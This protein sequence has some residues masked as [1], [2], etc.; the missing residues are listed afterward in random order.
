[1]SEIRNI[2]TLYKALQPYI[3]K[4]IAKASLGTTVVR[5]V[6]SG[7]GD[8]G[9]GDGDGGVTDHSELTNVTANQHHNQIHAI[10]GADHTG[11]LAHSS[12]S[13][14]T[15]SDH[16]AP[17]TAGDGIDLSGQQVSV[18]VTDIIDTSTGLAES[19][20]NI[21]I[22]YA[23]TG[24]L[25]V[26]SSQLKIG[27]PGSVAANSTNSTG[28]ATHTHAVVA[29]S[30]PGAS[31]T[32]LKSTSAGGLT[33]ESFL[34]NGS[35][36]ALGD[37]YA[38]QSGF[39]VIN[40]THDGDHAHVIINPTVGWS[41]D[42]QFGLDVDDNLLV[43]GWIVGKHAIQV[44]GAKLIAHFDGPEPYETNFDGEGMGHMGQVPT[45]LGGVTFHKGKFL[46]AVQMA[47]ATTNLVTNPSFETNTTGWSIFNDTGGNLA[48]SR[49]ADDSKFGVYSA[50]LTSTT[51]NNSQFY[52]AVSGGFVSGTSYSGS[53]WMRAASSE[54]VVVRLRRNG[55][56][57]E[58]YVSQTFA[59][60]TEWQR[61][62]LSFT[63]AATV[64]GRISIEPQ[65]SGTVYVDGVQVE[66]LAYATPYCDG[67]LGGYSASGVYDGSGHSWSGTAHA[68]T[69][70]RLASNLHY[71]GISGNINNTVG[72]VMLWAKVA[73]LG[74][75]GV[76][77][78]FFAADS[79][80]NRYIAMRFDSS[81][82][83]FYFWD[84]SGTSKS[85]YAPDGEWHHYAMSSDGSTVTLYVD[86]IS[87]DSYS[88]SSPITENLTEIYVGCRETGSQLNG[89]IDDFAIFDRAVPA[90][91]IRAIYESNAP[92][93]GET[94]TWHWRAGR[95]RVWA[96][97][98]GLWMLNASGTAVLGAY[99]G[100]ED[101]PSTTKSWGGQ[102]LS[103]SD[104]LIGD[105]NRGGYVKWDD[106]A[107]TLNVK[108]TILMQS[109]S[110]G[111]TNFSDAGA[112]VT[113][114]N[115]D[116]IPN[117]STYGR[118]QLAA[119][120]ASGLVLLDQTITG[121]YGL[122]LSTDISAGHILLSET[123]G[124]MDDVGDGSTYGRVRQTILGAGYIQVGSGTKDSTL[125]GW[126]IDNTEI[127]GQLDGV[128]QVTMG[129][130][131]RIKAGSGAVVLDAAGVNIDYDTSTSGTYVPS[132]SGRLTWWDNPVTRANIGLD[133]WTYHRNTGTHRQKSFISAQSGSTDEA[134]L[135]VRAEHG[136]EAFL[137]LYAITPS[138]G[139][140]TEGHA[141]LWG[142]DTIGL[143]TGAI[144]R[145]HVA[146]NGRVGI[147]TS[148]P[149]NHLTVGGDVDGEL[150]VTSTESR[151]GVFKAHDSGD[152]V[153]IG[154]ESNHSFQI[155]ANNTRLAAFSTGGQVSFYNTSSTI[156][157]VLHPAGDSYI[158]GGNVGINDAT[159]SY[160]LDVN[161]TIRH[162]GITD[163]SDKRLKTSLR[164]VTSVT[165]KLAALNAYSFLWRDTVPASDSYRDGNRKKRH[166]G[167]IA[168]E[169]KAQFPALVDN[170]P[171]TDVRGNKHKNYLAINSSSMIAVLVESI[172]E[173]NTRL[174]TLENG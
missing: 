4:R 102:T 65:S 107:A 46:K 159:P 94:S 173:L 70:S 170:V 148:S 100:D 118:T 73:D 59:V 75:T 121:T 32:L 101:N 61:F 133:M 123:I 79:I 104:L 120:N 168:Q 153:H 40:H 45:L 78:M 138:G 96:D 80:I 67:S 131:G 50:K 10:D 33:L 156:K 72:T 54:N 8:G 93:F 155:V 169:V 1:M 115:L 76:S 86:G 160:K 161:G 2:T 124:D 113:A 171:Y 151:K 83:I 134:Q 99:A 132:D 36:T 27:T 95:N 25:V 149:S 105:A 17:V 42:E 62:T 109:G 63:A 166:V 16:H 152:F 84:W 57:Y 164:R 145:I 38:A 64:T 3:D 137:D 158:N 143:W 90:D 55:P 28:V 85:G 92:I 139:L 125:D 20:N 44:D 112:I 39:R 34:S 15:D 126:K 174:E 88:V 13:G 108:G 7:S 74:S 31:E 167:L 135:T 141:I 48:V 89:L 117:G 35:I 103:E 24:G 29:S 110:T 71:S 146:A 21:Q 98:E 122:V 154:T 58:T 77:Y 172:K 52:T 119:L 37:L 114:D 68:S 43:R 69:S 53:V 106:S 140:A 66:A 142:D 14:I 47:E 6:S 49:V 51:I 41:L 81:G 11:S 128:D 97:V 150:A 60:T 19:G 9:S 165:D 162:Y 130:D 23:L 18:D 129:T 116:G 26:Q 12:L 157:N 87:V 111:I 56:S 147:G 91:E 82:N 144:E 163:S 30:S 136:A 5:T 22:N 127:V